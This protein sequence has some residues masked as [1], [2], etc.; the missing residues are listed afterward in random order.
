MN[1]NTPDL[2][3]LSEGQL[4]SY[5]VWLIGRITYLTEDLRVRSCIKTLKKFVEG[6][7]TRQDLAKAAYKVTLTKLVKPDDDEIATHYA[8]IAVLRAANALLMLD[9]TTHTGA[10]Q[11]TADAVAMARSY[12]GSLCGDYL[13]KEKELQN[14]R[15]SSLIDERYATEAPQH[16]IIY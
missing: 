11:S 9:S 5:T 15:V 13:N 1:H 12:T 7:A 10:V 16:H 6:N 3:L 14:A 2:E 4:K 8:N